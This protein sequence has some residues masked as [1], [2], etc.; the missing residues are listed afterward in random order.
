MVAAALWMTA[1]AVFGTAVAGF[2][3]LAAEDIHPLAIP[4]FRALFAAPLVL[5]WLVR[6]DKEESADGFAPRA[7]I[8]LHLA[9]AAAVVG[10]IVFFVLAMTWMS[11]ADATALVL[12]GPVFAVAFAALLFGERAGVR[13]W[14]AVALG[15]GGALIVI[16]P[17]GEAT[18]LGAVFGLLSAVAAAADW[19]LLK[20]IAQIDGM[21]RATAWLTVLMVPLALPLAL[22]VW[23]WPPIPALLALA[24]AALAGTLSQA[25]SV[26][27]F[28]LGR[29]WHLSALSYLNV[30]FAAVLGWLVFAEDVEPWTLIGGAVIV[31]ASVALAQVQA[32]KTEA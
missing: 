32:A 31:A 5:P 15:L 9:R 8:P 22:F 24:G 1:A 23:T 14:V 25:L 20:R 17:V 13:G 7:G 21:G 29:L 3:R 28:A 18:T 11:I 27:A 4:F 19:L 26:R 10:T 12:A 30:P 16:G 2:F 6:R